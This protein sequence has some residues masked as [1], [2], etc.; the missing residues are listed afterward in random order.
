MKIPLIFRKKYVD[1]N[2]Y[3]DIAK[4]RTVFVD[5]DKLRERGWD[6]VL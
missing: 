2:E 5:R 4:E 1:W 6:H 3:I